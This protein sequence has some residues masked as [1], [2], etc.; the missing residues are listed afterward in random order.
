MPEIENARRLKS[1]GKGR[2]MFVYEVEF[3]SEVNLGRSGFTPSTVCAFVFKFCFLFY[4]F[5]FS[6]SYFFPFFFLEIG[7]G[8]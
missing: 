2:V 6:F 1:Q 8:E 5:R 3:L 7:F 4:F